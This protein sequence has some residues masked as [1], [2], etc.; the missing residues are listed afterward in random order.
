MGFIIIYND[1]LNLKVH[2]FRAMCMWKPYMK[3][4]PAPLSMGGIFE[5]INVQTTYYIFI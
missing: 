3:D 2:V 4:I 1:P 5:E